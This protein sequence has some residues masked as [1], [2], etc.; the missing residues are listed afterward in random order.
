M[1][2]SNTQSAAVVGI[3]I[4]AAA[5]ILSDN[6]DSGVVRTVQRVLPGSTGGSNDDRVSYE[7][8]TDSTSGV[9]DTGTDAVDTAV[10]RAV[11]AGANVGVDLPDVTDPAVTGAA[12]DTIIDSNAALSAANDVF[13]I[14]SGNGS[15]DSG[16]N[17]GQS[18]NPISGLL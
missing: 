6:S 7:Q 11:D 3:G 8:F 16:S 5:V 13:N 10:D 14:A 15:S 9:V 4:V 2:I 17:Q 18:N 12:V 1:S